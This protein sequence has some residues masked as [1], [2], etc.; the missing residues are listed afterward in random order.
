MSL[1]FVS[2]P[3]V[4]LI[5]TGGTYTP[6]SQTKLIAINKTQSIL[7]GKTIFK[8]E[9]CINCHKLDKTCRQLLNNL[10]DRYEKEFLYNFIRNEDSLLKAKHPEV[11]SLKKS[12]NGAN[13]LHDKKHLSDTQ[14][15]DL[16]DFIASFD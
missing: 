12:Y 4:I 2:L 9:Q 13:G 16:L 3:F 7:R 10:R 5:Q 15:E 6:T 8:K 1:I 11:I 14:I